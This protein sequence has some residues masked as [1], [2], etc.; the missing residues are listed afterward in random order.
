M[1][2][3]PRAR[4]ACCRRCR[5]A[6]HTKE[7]SAMSDT[8]YVGARKG[9][10][11]IEKPAGR[12]SYGEPEFLGDPVTAVLR[13]SRDG[14]L[15]AALNLGHFGVKMRRSDDGGKTWEEHATPA[16]PVQPENAP[17]PAWKLQL[18]WTL[19]PGGANEPGVLWAGTIPGGLFRS[20][21]RGETWALQKSLWEHPSR[22]EWMGGGYDAAGIPSIAIDP[23]DS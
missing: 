21:D 4:S 15:Y 6:E 23:R 16:Y 19:E 9:F 8:L 7:R 12:W 20:G 1:P 18:V 11:T 10:F 22:T 13:D 17:G 14:T 5:A 2:S 3:R